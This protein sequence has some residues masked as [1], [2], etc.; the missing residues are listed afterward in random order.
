MKKRK[1]LVLA[2]KLGRTGGVETHLLN[3][4]KYMK[5]K[6]LI[7]IIVSSTQNLLSD[8]VEQLSS[9]GLTLKVFECIFWVGSR[10]LKNGSI[11]TI[12][13]FL[14]KLFSSTPKIILKSLI[15]PTM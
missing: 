15:E 14:K 2:G 8:K 10:N 11:I 13:I 3:F 7:T 1:L 5:E 4:S 6:Y 12:Q 9:N